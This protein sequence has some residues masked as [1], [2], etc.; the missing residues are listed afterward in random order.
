MGDLWLS[1]GRARR[2]ARSGAFL[3]AYAGY[4]SVV[5]GLGQRLLL[6]P[7]IVLLPRRRGSLV[8]AWLRAHARA[9]LAMARGLAGVRVSV[10]GAIAPGSCI[11]VMNHQSL[12]DIPIGLALVPGPY[13]L[14]PTRDRYMRGIPG[15]SP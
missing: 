6:W 10:D 4:L 9:T 11:V 1:A 2:A 7:A 14:I 5:V 3:L 8:R 15:V 12:L 13:P